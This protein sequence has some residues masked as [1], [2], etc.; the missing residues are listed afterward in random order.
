V[1]P[2]PNTNFSLACVLF[3][4]GSITLGLNAAKSVGQLSENYITSSNVHSASGCC[5][6]LYLDSIRMCLFG[7]DLSPVDFPR[8]DV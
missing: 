4:Q 8:S 5:K 7:I 6:F 2:E 3:E 1:K